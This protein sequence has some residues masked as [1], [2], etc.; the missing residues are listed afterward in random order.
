MVCM[1][2]TCNILPFVNNILYFLLHYCPE[3]FYP[4]IWNVFTIC[5]EVGNNL[6]TFNSAATIVIY[7]VF[8]TRY[9][10]LL[11]EYLCRLAG[12]W[13]SDATETGTNPTNYEIINGYSTSQRLKRNSKPILDAQR[14]RSYQ[15]TSHRLVN[16]PELPIQMQTYEMRRKVMKRTNMGSSLDIGIGMDGDGAA[17]FTSDIFSAGE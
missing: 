11:V 15:S 1:F 13:R 6:V 12:R 10:A 7:T 9:K 5:T 14:R 3:L 16:S 2:L 4:G 8:S 17:T